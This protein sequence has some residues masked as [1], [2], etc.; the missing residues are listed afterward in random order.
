M[1]E[2]GS[3]DSGLRQRLQALDALFRARLPMRLQELEAALA[4]CE[5]SAFRAGGEIA[6]LHDLL[7]RMAGTAGTFGC[8]ELGTRAKECECALDTIMNGELRDA[9]TDAVTR[10]AGHVRDY[11]QW[12]RR[13]VGDDI[14]ASTHSP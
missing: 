1:D 12:A 6:V 5:L 4:Q 14:I 13:H 9:D 8:R 7:H 3:D 2:A 10:V 11:L